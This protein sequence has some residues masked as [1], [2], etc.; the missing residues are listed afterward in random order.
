MGFQ[1]Y[2]IDASVIISIFYYKLDKNKKQ[3]GIYFVDSF[4]NSVYYRY[5]NMQGNERNGIRNFTP[6]TDGKRENNIG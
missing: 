5:T 3:D 4:Q 1:A 6:R 2:I